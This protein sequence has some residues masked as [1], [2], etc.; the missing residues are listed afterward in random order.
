[1]P[2][3]ARQ[4]IIYD[5]IDRSCLKEQPETVFVKERRLYGSPQML[6][7][8]LDG[9]RLYVTT[10]LFTPWDKEFYPECVK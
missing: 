2:R 8:S 9:K 10:S 5:E 6:Q 4:R 3:C 7:L 1:M